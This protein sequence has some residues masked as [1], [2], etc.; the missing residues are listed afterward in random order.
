MLLVDLFGIAFALIVSVAG[1]KRRLQWALREAVETARYRRVPPLTAREGEGL[2]IISPHLDDAV[3]SCSGLLS[4]R[5]GA[6]VVT[7]CTAEPEGDHPLTPW[8]RACGFRAGDSV[9]TIRKREDDAALALFGARAVWLDIVE[10]QYEPL[11]PD[12]VRGRLV[13]ALSELRP[14]CVGVPMGISHP[15]HVVVAEVSL[16]LAQAHAGIDWIVYEELPYFVS[17]P[18]LVA[19]RQE[20]LRSWGVPG[21]LVTVHPERVRKSAALHRYRTQCRALW[22]A[23][24]LTLGEERYW[25]YV[26]ARR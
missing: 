22:E 14:T 3:L 18:G 7:V 26:P 9:M 12:L 25:P 10:G 13:Q 24:P 15:D 8:D 4:S 19:E 1:A 23:L 6:T 16:Q 17:H 5:P 11:N 20:T 2:V 21:S